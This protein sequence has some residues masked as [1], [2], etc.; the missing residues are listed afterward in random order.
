MARLATA[1]RYEEPTYGN[2]RKPR[3][4]GIGKWGLLPVLLVMAGV[5]GMTL[6]FRFADWRAVLVVA[7]L[8]A[9]AAGLVA[10]QDRH[11]KTLAARLGE[12]IG[13]LQGK[14]RQRN[15]YRSGPLGYI[16]NGKFQLPG[17][18]ARSTVYEGVDGHDR[19]FAVVNLPARGHFTVALE[20]QP[21]GSALVDPEQIDNWIANWGGFLASLGAEPG[22]VG[23][24]AIV[25]TAPDSGARLRRQIEGSISAEAPEVAR[26]MLE[27]AMWEYPT[28]S[29]GTRCW[30]TLTYR[31]VI[32]AGGKART[33]EQVVLDL[34]S[35]LPGLTTR[36]N[37][38]GAGAARPL[39]GE[40]LAKIV[41][42]SYDPAVESVIDESNRTGEPLDLAWENIGPSAQVAGWRAFKHDSAVSRSWT[43]SQA[44]R[45]QVGGRL[46]ERLLVSHPDVERKRIALLYRPLNV[47]TAAAAAHA[48]LNQAR[49]RVRGSDNPTA[50][51]EAALEAAQAT[52][53]EESRG[54]GLENFGMVV[55]VS[56]STAE[57][58]E[59]A[60][61][62]ME[63][64][65]A[66]S[67]QVQ[68]RPA[69]GSHDVAF[70]A[71]LPLGVVPAAF[72]NVPT[73]LEGLL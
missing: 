15:A 3:R 28:G 55:T 58:L 54:A 11:G 21:D 44:P 43:M 7:F 59:V 70:A 27:D 6:A 16:E 24:Q 23:A 12:R 36:L 19:P 17:I 71:A 33:P 69:Y 65:L 66:P 63:T 73:D 5:I 52:A 50:S 34:A 62:T 48:D 38:T 41:R 9:V 30:I 25:E 13:F 29:S 18:L 72:T 68:L 20:V 2:W 31:A 40:E 4:A 10:F 14:A 47:G 60:A 35:R 56:A 46:L 42:V 57:S 45:G 37:T 8:T 61:V 53:R 67:A 64:T 22:L 51:A 1:E 49:A 32:R 26:A 39:S